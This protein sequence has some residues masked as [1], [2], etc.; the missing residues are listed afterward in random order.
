M[1]NWIAVPSMVTNCKNLVGDDTLQ[2]VMTL[3]QL[4]TKITGA[5]L[6]IPMYVSSLTVKS[7]VTNCRS[8]ITDCKLLQS[9]TIVG[10][11]I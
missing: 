3:L 1:V 8:V 2:L 5:I 9:V 4:V 6:C 7:F 10:T 11:A